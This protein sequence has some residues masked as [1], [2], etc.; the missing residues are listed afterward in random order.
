MWDDY[1]KLYRI[2]DTNDA[3]ILDEKAGKAWSLDHGDKTYIEFS[4][5]FYDGI[6]AGRNAFKYKD[7]P[8]MP[9]YQK[10]PNRT[11]LGKECTVF[12]TTA[13]GITTT[14]G[15]W[16][17]I[18]FFRERSGTVAGIEINEIRTA[19]SYSETVPANSFKVPSDYTL[20]P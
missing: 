3:T 2:G 15:G 10:L 6:L 9:G 18:E 16:N 1:G 7:N 20:R 5:S 19:T 11:I 8:N 14:F 4:A 13:A 17:E 12:S